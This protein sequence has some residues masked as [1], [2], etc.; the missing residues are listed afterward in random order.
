MIMATIT[1][2][3]EGLKDLANFNIDSQFTQQYGTQVFN[4]SG[5]VTPAYEQLCMNLNLVL[6]DV[7]ADVAAIRSQIPNLQRN[8]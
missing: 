5:E 3:R 4:Y 8:G 7:E 1:P 6:D 2:N